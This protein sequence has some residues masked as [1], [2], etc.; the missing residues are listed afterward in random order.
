VK[1]ESPGGNPRT[2]PY[3][4]GKSGVVTVLHGRIANPL[5]HRGIYPNL[6]TVDFAV[7]DVFGGSGHDALSAD[8][9][10]DW[11]EPA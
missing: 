7:R 3:A 1:T 6:Y 8:V 5:D 10:E 11:L 2:P 4:R 9:H